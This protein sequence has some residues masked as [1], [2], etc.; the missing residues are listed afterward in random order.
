MGGGESQR[1]YYGSLTVALMVLLLGSSS[2]AQNS[3]D[4]KTLKLKQQSQ[5]RSRWAASSLD[6]IRAE[7]RYEACLGEDCFRMDT[8]SSASP[9]K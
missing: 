1:T 3:E 2:Y 6:Q 9:P 4:T 7:E 5:P 8:N